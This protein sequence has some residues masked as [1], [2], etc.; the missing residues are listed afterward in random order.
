MTPHLFKST[1][2]PGL[3]VC[4]AKRLT[5]DPRRTYEPAIKAAVV[6]GANPRDAYETW[7]KQYMKGRH[8]DLGRA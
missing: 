4:C 5:L 7:V 2:Y 6:Y 8:H 3:W 1:V